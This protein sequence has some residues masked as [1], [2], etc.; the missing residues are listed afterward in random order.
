MCLIVSPFLR[1]RTAIYKRDPP[2]KKSIFFLF[3]C[4]LSP[5]TL[6]FLTLFAA[7]VSA[8]S[9]RVVDGGGMG[10]DRDD[11]TEAAAGGG[12]WL[13]MLGFFRFT[14]FSLLVWARLVIWTD[15]I[16]VWVFV[17]VWLGFIGFWAV[18]L[19]IGFWV[20]GCK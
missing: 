1:N 5:F 12:R 9:C 6:F 10:V 11:G 3:V 16:W 4:L 20:V 13:P 14:V 17:F 8:P 2:Q 15:V 18:C 19:E 7:C